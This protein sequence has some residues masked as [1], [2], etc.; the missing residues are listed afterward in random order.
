MQPNDTC[1]Q[2]G[3]VEA[4]NNPV[5]GIF[6]ISKWSFEKVTNEEAEAIESVK[7]SDECEQSL[8]LF[9]S[10]D[11]EPDELL[12]QQHTIAFK[13]MGT[14]KLSGVQ[15]ILQKARDFLVNGTVVPVRVLPEPTNPI[16]KNA[17]AFQCYLD[18]KWHKF[19]YAVKEVTGEIHTA[20]MKK[21]IYS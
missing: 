20:L 19:G 18:N 12:A 13:V 11:S 21:E 9:S 17:I 5:D 3:R 16:D 2:L 4:L 7:D 15:H 14:T 6:I 8:S 10:P 1:G